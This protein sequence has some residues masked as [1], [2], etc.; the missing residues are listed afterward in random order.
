VTEPAPEHSVVLYS[1][2]P[3]WKAGLPLGQQE[4]AQDHIAFLVNGFQEGI[5]ERAGPFH[6]PED[7][8]DDDELVG[9]VIYRLDRAR[10]DERTRDDPAVRAGL[11]EFR[12]RAWHP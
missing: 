7:I 3:A 4:G 8:V 6:G 10:A 11:L 5:V 9:L 12:A 1:R 2:G